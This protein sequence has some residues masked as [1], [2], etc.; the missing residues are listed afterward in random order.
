MKVIFSRKGFDSSSGYGCSPILP[1]GR[2]LSLPIPD[3]EDNDEYRKLMFDGFSYEDIIKM[4]HPMGYKKLED[5]NLLHCHVDPDIY[6]EIKPREEGW[7]PSFGQMSSALTQLRNNNVT[8]GDIFLFFGWFRQTEW[9]NGVLR[10]VKKAPNLHIIYGYMQVGEM[11]C[12]KTQE[13]PAWLKSHPHASPKYNKEDKNV[14]FIASERLSIIPQ[15]PGAG[16]FNFN[17]NRVLTKDGYSRSRWNLP[18]F[19]KDINITGC[20]GWKDEGYFQSGGR[21]QEFIWT[22]TDEALRWVKQIILA[23]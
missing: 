23:G 14:I 17:D 20:N 10:F 2:L 7:R 15:M 19:F 4:L 3:S 8:T 16:V 12:P 5:K 13:I 9:H 18:D 1:D 21:G 11:L 6:K 22:A